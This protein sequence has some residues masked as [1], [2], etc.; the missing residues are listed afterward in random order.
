MWQM[1]NDTWHMSW[2]HIISALIVELV[3]VIWYYNIY[4]MLY[5]HITSPGSRCPMGANQRL[6][7]WVLGVCVLGVWVLGV[8]VLGV[9]VLGVCVLG[10]FLLGV[11]VWELWRQRGMM[12]SWMIKFSARITKIFHSNLGE[13]VLQGSY[14]WYQ[15]SHFI[16]WWTIFFSQ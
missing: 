2:W 3:L 8:W 4:N 13:V 11:C 16:V 14:F 12:R 6:G 10:V 9:C 1:G 7:V 5:Y 15:R